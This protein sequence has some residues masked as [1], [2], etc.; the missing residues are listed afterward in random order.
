MLADSKTNFVTIESLAKTRNRL[1]TTSN[2]LPTALE[3]SIGQGEAAL[4]MLLMRDNYGSLSA[5][6]ATTIRAPKDRVRVWLLDEK[7]PTA[8]GWKPAEVTVQLS[9]TAPVSAA[10]VDSQAA[11]RGSS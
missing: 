3:I 2:P 5:V 4:L 8:Q 1:D 6:N 9:D 10:I 11:Q 7:F